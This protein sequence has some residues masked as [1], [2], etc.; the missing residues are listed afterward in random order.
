MCLH[1]NAVAKYNFK[2]FFMEEGAHEGKSTEAYKSYN[3]LM[4]HPSHG[5]PCTTL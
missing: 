4:A 3:G 2:Y 5:S 1:T